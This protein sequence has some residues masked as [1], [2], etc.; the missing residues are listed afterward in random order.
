MLDHFGFLAPIYDRVIKPK[1]PEKLIQLLGLPIEGK[2]LDA[3]G[4]TGRISQTLRGLSEHIVVADASLDML[5][6]A[7]A[8]GGLITVHSLSEALPFPNHS[9][10]RVL[11]VDA[12]HHVYAQDQTINELWRVVKPGGVVVIE[13]PDIRTTIIKL[14]ALAEKIALM[15]SRFLSPGAIADLF[16]AQTNSQIYVEGYNAW[17]VIEKGAQA[18]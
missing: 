6:Q 2:I 8:K 17:I 4:G 9:F 10:E 14:V 18:L 16:P 11:M 13:E 3:G 7:Q 5:K 1:N 15:R 12:L